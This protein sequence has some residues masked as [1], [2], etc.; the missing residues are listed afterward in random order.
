MLIP[1]E[2]E[3][4]IRA[5]LAAE[6]AQPVYTYLANSIEKVAEPAPAAAIPYSLVAAIDSTRELGPLVDASGVPLPP[7]ADDEIVLTSWAARDL[8]AATG[9]RIRLTFFE[10][11]TMHGQVAERSAEFTLRA[12]V[13]LTEPATPYRRT[14]ARALRPEADAGQRSRPD[15]G[16]G[17]RHRPGLDQPLGGAV[18]RGLPP[19]PAS[20]RHLLEEPPH[21]AQSLHFTGGRPADLAQPLRAI[22]VIPDSSPGDAGARQS[23][24]TRF[25][26]A[27]GDGNRRAAGPDA[28]A[29]RV[30][31]HPAPPARPVGF[32]RHHAVRRA[33]PA[34]EFL[35]DRGRVDAGDAAVWPGRRTPGGRVGDA[36]GDGP[37]TT[38]CRPAVPRRGGGRRGARRLARRRRRMGLRLADAGRSQ[39]LVAGSR[40]DPVPAA[41]REALESGHRLCR[42]RARRAA[43]DRVGACAAR[44]AWPVRRLLAGQGER[45]TAA[46]GLTARPP[47][48]ADPAGLPGGGVAAGHRR[49]AAGR[50]VAGGRLRRRRG[51]GPDRPAA[52]PPRPRCKAAGRGPAASSE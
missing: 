33:V 40:R 2:A 18:S 17:G 6:R 43:G 9:D 39:D 50:R 1:P 4:A 15:A 7:L 3:T 36:A 22:D 37:A 52:V 11:E 28:G 27:A 35:R 38:A 12:V 30:P 16:G 44:E 51:I 41:V 45:T 24:G 31:F 23:R 25:H 13:E 42:R 14:T 34:V 48:A 26:P 19:H 10:P 32:G 5:A 29:A 21:D 46:R 8:S 47:L 49:P 20:G